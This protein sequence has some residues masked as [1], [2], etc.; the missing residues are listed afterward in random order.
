PIDPGVPDERKNWLIKD[1]SAKL[2]L[3]DMWADIPADLLAVPLFR[4]SGEMSTIREEDCL[5]PDLPASSTGSAYIM[6]TSGSTG[7]PKGV[8][9]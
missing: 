2:L 4:L 6:Y 1:C 8:V 7:T 5:N 9:V 3:T